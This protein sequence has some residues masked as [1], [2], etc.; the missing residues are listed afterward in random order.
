MIFLDEDGNERK[1]TWRTIYTWWYRYKNHGITGVEIKPRA[2][3]GVRRKIS[4]EQLLEAVNQVIHHFRKDNGYNATDIYRKIIELGVISRNDLA[5]TTY[6]RFVKEYELLKDD[7]SRNKKRLAFA[8]PYANDLWQGD[9]MFGPYVKNE[10]GTSAQTKLIAFLDDASRLICHGEFFFDE[11]INSLVTILRT[12]FYKR[13]IPKQLYVDNGS[14]YTSKEISLICAR[15][16]CVL[17]NAPVRDGAAKGK[18]ERFF[19]TVR[20]IFLSRQLD[21]SSLHI[22]NKQFTSWVEDE[23]NHKIHSSLDMK[24]I[25]RFGLDRNRLR[26][27]PNMQAA[28]EL[29]YNEEDRTVLADNTFSFKNIRYEAPAYL[30]NKKI[31]VRFDRNKNETPVIVYYKGDRIGE[32]KPVNFTA[33]ALLRRGGAI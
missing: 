19:R 5:P 18:I 31:Q 30:Y 11:N 1:F 29:F 10:N 22:F 27:L 26:Y 32:A 2:D 16:G 13:G 4:P 25:D 33:N 24:P 17:S 12:A 6:Y 23:Y 14:I 7:D 21:L 8:M 15:V 28:D 9:T 3:K 20:D